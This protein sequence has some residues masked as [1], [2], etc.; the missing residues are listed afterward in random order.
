MLYESTY[1]GVAGLGDD[2]LQHHGIKGQKWG[3]RRF[4]NSDGTLTEA[5]KQHRSSLTYHRSEPSRIAKALSKINDNIR[6][7][8]ENQHDYTI[9]DD[10]GKKVGTLSLF[11]N[12]DDEMNVMWVSVNKKERGKGYGQEIM[13]HVISESTKAGFKKLTLEVPGSSPDARHIYE[14]L[15]FKETSVISDEDDVWE[16]LTAMELD[17]TRRK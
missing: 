10:S 3:V 15:G 17:L 6:R 7:N 16:G 2:S 11:K 5:G 1:Y 12:S 14:K 9:T 4:Q 8:I 13:R